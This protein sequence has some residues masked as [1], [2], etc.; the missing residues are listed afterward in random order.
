[1]ASGLPSQNASSGWIDASAELTQRI[2]VVHK[3]Q[4]KHP[5]AAAL[6]VL[7]SLIALSACGGGQGDVTSLDAAATEA[8]VL[9]TAAARRNVSI[10]ANLGNIA[11]SSTT[12]TTTAP[13]P[14]TS[15][16]TSTVTKT[17][18]TSGTTTSATATT[19]STAAT[20]PTTGAGT[21][22]PVVT[23]TTAS[24]AALAAL[25]NSPSI[26]SGS[27]KTAAASTAC[28]VNDI[29]GWT[30]PVPAKADATVPL[31]HI[32][33]PGSRL[34]YISAATGSDSTGQIYFWNGSAIIDASGSTTNSGGQAYGTDPMNPSAAVK[35]FKRWAKVGPRVSGGDIGTAGMRYNAAPTTRA[36]APDWWLFARGETFDLKSDVMSFVNEVEPSATN[37]AV[38][39][40]VVSGGR[41]AT[42]P[43]VV[44]AY[45]SPCAARPRFVNPVHG[46]VTRFDSA[47]GT[48]LKNVAY[49]SLHFDAHDRT[50]GAGSYDGI[51]L[52]GQPATATNILFED[53]W[54]DAAG[55]NIGGNGDNNSQVTLRRSLVTDVHVAASGGV[56]QGV[57]YAGG[58]AGSLRIEE[59]VLLRN[60]FTGDP[61]KAT[62]PPT[63][64]QVWNMYNRNMYLSGHTQSMKSGVF[65]SVSMLGSSG[66][67]FRPGMQIE[68]NFFYNGYL[69]M[70][71][72]GGHADSYGP[73]GTLLNNVLQKFSGSGTNDNRGQPGW[74]MSLVSGAA[75]VVV[76]GNIVTNTALTSPYPTYA[77]ALD[78][79]NWLCYSHTFKG[80]TRNNTIQ[81]NIFDSGAAPAAIDVT[82][83]V[84][85]ESTPG[86][87][88]W[89]YAGVKG[90]KVL[91]N[92]MVNAS[93]K[94]WRYL[95]K[96]GALGT[97]NDTQVTANAVYPTRA[98]A[99]SAQGWP[100]ANRTLRTYLVSKGVNVANNSDGFIE[101]FG[102]AT[103]MRKGQ[104]AS[105]WTAKSL[106]NY[107]REGFNRPALP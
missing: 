6:T 84:N 31:T 21:T 98:A 10:V 17:T 78:T 105:T 51:T 64:T 49:L 3:L 34:F 25:V 72:D 86:C 62:W 12:T 58:T 11:K 95:T 71:G 30:V 41:S 59:S 55:I 75:G 107:T 54:F 46:F 38:T 42:E 96:G 100:D 44:G 91:N 27:I 19:P 101:Y 52:L 103:Q 33:Q 70:G 45:G 82:D 102:K 22:T 66:D 81:N 24:A 97:T 13:V 63:G 87:A 48:P 28:G 80:A 68:R 99:A 35:P 57:F 32:K 7:S 5:R 39:S 89:T 16:S 14:T 56:E 26:G 43:Q 53:V 29:G 67:Q 9:E 60:G 74:G 69:A 47:T 15:T 94:S 2:T 40:L 61:A 50:S 104:W 77:F 1:M 93:G 85:D 8:E 76:E 90:N 20:T 4:T 23:A 73:T 92:V 18:T 106:V 79:T 88:G 37:T 65:D 83:G 36:G